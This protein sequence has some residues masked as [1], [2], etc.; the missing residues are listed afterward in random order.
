MKAVKAMI[1]VENQDMQLQYLLKIAYQHIEK[2]DLMRWWRFG[3][4]FLSYFN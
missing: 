3:D 2:T 1:I 4:W